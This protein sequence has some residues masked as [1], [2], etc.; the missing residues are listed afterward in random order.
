MFPVDADMPTAET[1]PGSFGPAVEQTIP[2]KAAM[3]PALDEEQEQ[4]SDQELPE[5]LR[6]DI[7][8]RV[9]RAVRRSVRRAHRGL[10][11]PSR[12]AFMHMM[13]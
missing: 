12:V 4:W 13:R 8:M 6:E 10:G 9:P 3:H 5:G 1:Q 2:E 7:L 11:H